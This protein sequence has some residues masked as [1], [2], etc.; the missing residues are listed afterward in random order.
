MSNASLDVE[1]S[2]N[3]PLSFYT[4]IEGNKEGLI[5]F[6]DRGIFYLNHNNHKHYLLGR[7]VNMD[8][9]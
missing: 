9:I 3:I 1:K 8:D 2:S 7:K 4:Y 5:Y 6:V